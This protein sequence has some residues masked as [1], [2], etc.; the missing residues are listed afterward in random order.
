M[1]NS[2][3]K[4]LWKGSNPKKKEEGD[5]ATYTTPDKNN[6]RSTRPNDSHQ[7]LNELDA[8][9]RTVEPEKRTAALYR[10]SE[11]RPTATIALDQTV[12]SK[13]PQEVTFLQRKELPPNFADDVL[14]CEMKI[15]EGQLNMEI[16][17]KL[18]YLYSQAMECYDSS[19]RSKYDVFYQRL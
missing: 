5:Q 17:D 8:N 2:V 7:P 13:P 11:K 3:K 1:F 14:A 6:Y 16:V 15:E 12:V 4:Y 19:D 18:I 9:F 10:S